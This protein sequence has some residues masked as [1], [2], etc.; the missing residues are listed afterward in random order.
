YNRDL[1]IPHNSRTIV[2]DIK[3]RMEVDHHYSSDCNKDPDHRRACSL[4]GNH[5]YNV[6]LHRT[7]NSQT[8]MADS[9]NRMEIG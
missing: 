4:L 6:D 1:H 9:E 5:Y 2:A 8:V 7:H 3:N